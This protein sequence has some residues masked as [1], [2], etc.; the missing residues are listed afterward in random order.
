M[1]RLQRVAAIQA[2]IEKATSNQE[3]YQLEEQKKRENLAATVTERRKKL[4]EQLS[5][6]EEAMYAEREQLIAR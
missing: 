4:A 1:T 3:K 5:Q 2:R 6:E